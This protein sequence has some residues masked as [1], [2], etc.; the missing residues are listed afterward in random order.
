MEESEEMLE[1]L[2]DRFGEPRKSVQ[3]LLMIAQLKARAHGLF[4]KEIKQTGKELK[5]VLFEKAQIDVSQIPALL[6]VCSPMLTFTMD[7]EQ[8]YFIYVL[9]RNT[10][11]KDRDV[12]EV[13]SELLEKMQIL[14]PH[15]A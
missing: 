15:N 6:S 9:K 2:I 4:I 5:I 3:N 13:L 14:L 11:E 7:P 1:E 12:L 10:R 8:P